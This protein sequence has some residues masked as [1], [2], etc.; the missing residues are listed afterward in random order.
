MWKKRLLVTLGILLLLVLFRGPLFRLCCTYHVT[1]KRTTYTPGNPALEAEVKT[2]AA[3]QPTGDAQK[4]TD[5]ALDLTSKRLSFTS[6]SCAVD[7][8]ITFTT[9]KTHCVGYAAYFSAVFNALAQQNGLGKI[10]HSW[11]VK[12][13][14]HLFGINVHHYLHGGFFR[15]HDFC[16]IEN[17]NTGE[18]WYVDPS[19]EDY[20]GITRISAVE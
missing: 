3:T 9:R 10:V 19:L 1:G 12:G 11:P 4:L 2:A 13:E 15:D 20:S 5:A 7:P 6:S 16:V 17:I 8:A 14:L 18:K